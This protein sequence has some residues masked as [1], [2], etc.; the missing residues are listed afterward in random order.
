MVYGPKH[1]YIGEFKQDMKCGEGKEI[2]DNKD[3]YTGGWKDD[4]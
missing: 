2:Y 3:V 4:L 1:T